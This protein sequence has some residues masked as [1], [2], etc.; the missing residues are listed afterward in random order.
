MPP[1]LSRIVLVDADTVCVP[2]CE[3]TL[4]R[5]FQ[6]MPRTA[7]AAMGMSGSRR[8]ENVSGILGLGTPPYDGPQSGVVMIH[9]DRL[10]V[11]DARFCGGG[12]FPWW[13]CAL[14]WHGS[15]VNK[16]TPEY[17]WPFADQE[18]FR[19]LRLRR[20]TWFHVLPCGMH[21]DTQ[22]LQGL[23]KR[24]VR[25]L[26]RRSGPLCKGVNVSMLLS[27]SWPDSDGDCSVRQAGEQN[28]SAVAFTHSAGGMGGWAH[29]AASEATSHLMTERSRKARGDGGSSSA[30]ASVA[31]R[32]K[33]LCA[34]L[35]EWQARWPHQSTLDSYMHILRTASYGPLL[36]PIAPCLA[37]VS[38]PRSLRRQLAR[39]E[40]ES[41]AKGALRPTSRR[42]GSPFGLIELVLILGVIGLVL[43]LVA[44]QCCMS[45]FP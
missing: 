30:S 4:A 11:L 16:S 10:R 29:W 44:L 31:R 13:H 36:A 27:A 3:A 21:A 24:L 20:P 42:Q 26:P 5:E 14:G 25:L 15:D 45:Q 28:S 12:G 32:Y 2:P 18:V 1:E 19:V 41:A 39:A 7:W 8:R 40:A 17:P 23:V 38:R 22:V 9:L 34:M 35:Q 37:T 33:R 6:A 43:V